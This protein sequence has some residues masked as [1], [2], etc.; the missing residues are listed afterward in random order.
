MS[1]KNNESFR[2]YMQRWRIFVAQVQPALQKSEVTSYFIQTLPDPY[3]K[4]MLGTNAKDLADLV[5]IRERIDIQIRK[6]KLNSPSITE[7]TRKGQFSKKTEEK[8]NDVCAS[9]QF[10]RP[11]QYWAGGRSSGNGGPN[12]VSSKL[13]RGNEQRNN[14]PAKDTRLWSNFSCTNEELYQDLFAKQVI[15]HRLY[16]AVQPP[17]PAWYTPNATCIYHMGAVGHSIEDCIGFKRTVLDLIDAGLVKFEPE[18]QASITTNP[19]PNH[20]NNQVGQ[21]LWIYRPKE[22]LMISRSLWRSYSTI[23]YGPGT[24]KRPLKATVLTLVGV[25]IPCF[26]SFIS[27]R[28]GITLKLAK[29]SKPLSGRK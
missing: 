4:I 3:N 6:G 17:F 27:K 20:E 16:R 13:E 2:D 22:P 9:N 19:L 29:N 7:G 11:I 26:A 28:R 21:A 14:R 23:S 8:V 1:K 25:T 5:E 10:P 24:S 12:Q 15:G 18:D